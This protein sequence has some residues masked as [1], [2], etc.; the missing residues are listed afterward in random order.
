MTTTHS[1]SATPRRQTLVFGAV[2]GIQALLGF[3]LLAGTAVRYLAP[4]S[5]TVQ[6]ITVPPPVTRTIVEH[7]PETVDPTP[8]ALRSPPQDPFDPAP[9]R[10]RPADGLPPTGVGAATTTATTDA[11]EL[12]PVITPI[13]MTDSGRER[14]AQACRDAYPAQSRRLGEEGVVGVLVYVSPEGRASNVRVASSSGYPRLDDANV[15][16]VKAAGRACVARQEGGRAI[17]AWQVMSSRWTLR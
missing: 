15:A 1:P 10:I 13:R 3:A 5:I 6:P 4:R 14:L 8:P 2:V 11:P 16:C 9:P 7:P 12:P 17:G